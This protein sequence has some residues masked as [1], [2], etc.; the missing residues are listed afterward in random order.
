MAALRSTLPLVLVCLAPLAFADDKPAEPKPIP[1]IADEPKSVDAAVF[2]PPGL[3]KRATVRFDEAPLEDVV[4]WLTKEQGL[5]VLVDDAGLDDLG[6]GLDEPV[7]DHLDD[8]PVYLLLDRLKSLGLA[9]RVEDGIVHVTCE[10]RAEEVLSTRPYNIADLLD[11]GLSADEV[12]DAILSTVDAD[13]WAQ[14]GGGQAELT[15]IGDVLFVL[16]NDRGQRQIE[17]FFAGLRKHARQTFV[18][19]PAEHVVLREKLSSNVSVEFDDTRLSEAAERLAKDAG[20]DIRLYRDVRAREPITL[21]LRDQKLETVLNALALPRKLSWRVD[22]GVVWITTTKDSPLKVAFYDVRDLVSDSDEYDSLIDAIVS[23]VA[24]E[25][26]SENGGGDA[27]IRP[28]G[29]GTLVISQTDLVHAQVLAL[30]EQYRA[31]LRVSKPREVPDEDAEILT[32]HYKLDP[33]VAVEMQTALP[34]LVRPQT[35]KSEAQPDAVGEIA[36][37]KSAPLP[38]RPV[39]DTTLIASQPQ[40]VLRVVQTRG[41]HYEVAKLLRS[42]TE[43]DAWPREQVNASFG[44]G[45][46]MGISI[47]IGGGSGSFGVQSELQQTQGRATIGGRGRRGFG[48]NY[49]NQNRKAK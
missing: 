32:V 2:V 19:E 13:G 25:S 29:P 4:A 7:S 6:A 15:S 31:A 33:G 3:A 28:I 1:V 45:G 30:L 11:E 48:N 26:W 23:Q 9:W 36:I 12:V 16:Q 47:G 46:G 27:E 42:V 44:G 43:G 21:A 49:I 35:W 18:D 20:V 39:K 24:V 37:Y 41:T 17:A 14:N 5:T 34:K 38:T 40:A 8:Q 22:D 10:E